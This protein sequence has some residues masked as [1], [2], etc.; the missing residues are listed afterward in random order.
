MG[1]F[2]RMFEGSGMKYGFFFIVQITTKR[3]KANETIKEGGDPYTDVV[4]VCVYYPMSLPLFLCFPTLLFFFGYVFLTF[5]PHILCFLLSSESSRH[6]S[7]SFDSQP[8][9][10]SIFVNTSS[11]FK[12]KVCNI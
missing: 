3:V 12:I 9:N 4:C 6:R 11:L 2:Q 8:Y 10:Y 5:F 7:F 1:Y